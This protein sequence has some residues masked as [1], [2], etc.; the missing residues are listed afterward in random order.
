MSHKFKWM[1]YEGEKV[2]IDREIAPLLAKMWRLGI[3]TTSCCQAVC[4]RNCKHNR[5]RVKYKDG[6]EYYKVVKTPRCKDRVLIVFDSARS[7]EKFL[8]MVAQY[9]KWEPGQPDGMYDAIQGHS[10][11]IIERWEVYPCVDN[12]GVELRVIRLPVKQADGL[13]KRRKTVGVFIDDGCKRNDF[14]MMPQLYFPRKHLS[15]VEHRLEE[16][17]NRKR[18]K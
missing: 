6:S 18:H 4:S 7:Y 3:G 8:N 14:R 5:E 10:A 15:Y 12:L 9:V 2:R 11:S 16:A 13:P 1:T 17:L